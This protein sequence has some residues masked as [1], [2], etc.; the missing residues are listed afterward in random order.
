MIRNL[1]FRGNKKGRDFTMTY[2]PEIT[3]LD[4]WVTLGMDM[5]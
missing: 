3:L 2:V 5:Y 4:K 1:I